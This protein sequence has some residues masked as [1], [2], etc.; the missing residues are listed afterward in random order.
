MSA[1]VL[2]VKQSLHRVEPFMYE[3]LKQIYD[4]SLTQR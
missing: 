4:G 2:C 3:I 1:D